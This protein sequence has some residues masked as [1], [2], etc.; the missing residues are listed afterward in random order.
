MR[1]EERASAADWKSIGI[2]KETVIS[3]IV[4]EGKLTLRQAIG[5]WRG[6]IETVKE[7]TSDACPKSQSF[8]V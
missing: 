5:G 7:S 3:L 1:L 8:R 2:V 6:S 4:R